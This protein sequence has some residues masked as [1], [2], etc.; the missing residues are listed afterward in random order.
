MKLYGTALITGATGGLGSAV[1]EELARR[2]HD[3]VLTSRGV[4]A[5]QA[6]ADRLSATYGI[7][8]VAEPADLSTATG[9]TSLVAALDAKRRA[10]R[11]LVNNAG[12]ALNEGITGHSPE[13]LGAMLQVN[14]TALTELTRIYATRMAQADGGHILLVASMAAYMPAPMMAAYAA[15]KAYV[16]SLGHALHVE[17]A[18]AVGVTVLSPGYMETGFDAVS[19][20]VPSPATRRTALSPALVA[21]TGIDALASGKPSVVAGAANRMGAAMTR[22]VTRDLLARQ[23]LKSMGDR[24]TRP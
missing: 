5:L 8:A 2:G 4:T 21:R 14:V 13:R 7:K 22:F 9:A 17:L 15:S 12:F 18:P 19:G 24:F 20:F 10:P 6:L 16:L 1:A 23:V 11:V 3:L